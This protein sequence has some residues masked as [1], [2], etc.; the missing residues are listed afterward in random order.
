MGNVIQVLIKALLRCD[1]SAVRK[2]I[3]ELIRLHLV[4]LILA[5]DI[6][7]FHIEKLG[8]HNGI[9]KPASLKCCS[10]DVEVSGV[11]DEHYFILTFISM[12]LQKRSHNLS[13]SLVSL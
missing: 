3:I 8:P 12:L 5:V 7:P 2:V 4:I 11:Q 6:I 13:F 9:L 10:F 1:F